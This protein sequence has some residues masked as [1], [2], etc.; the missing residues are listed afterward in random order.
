[1]NK[2]I[3][4]TGIDKAAISNI[5]GCETI[6]LHLL[7]GSEGLVDLI[8]LAECFNEN[9]ISDSRGVDLLINHVLESSHCTIDILESYTCIN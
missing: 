2:V 6:L 5:I 4:D 9:A 3:F 8:H 7:E 1:M